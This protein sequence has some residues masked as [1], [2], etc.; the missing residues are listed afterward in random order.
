M[1]YFLQPSKPLKQGTRRLYGIA[2]TLHPSH[3]LKRP[4]F[5]EYAIERLYPKIGRE[6]AS[7]E[8]A[9]LE[10]LN[11]AVIFQEGYEP[12]TSPESKV[13]PA[14]LYNNRYR[15]SRQF[16]VIY[17]DEGFPFE[18]LSSDEE[19]E[20]HWLR[21]INENLSPDSRGVIIAGVYHLKDKLYPKDLYTDTSEFPKM[22]SDN[23]IKLTVVL[24][25]LPRELI[26]AI[27]TQRF[28]ER[29]MH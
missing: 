4:G 1:D 25:T 26:E 14:W 11:P 10:E 9:C 28:R 6:I 22:L 12:S 16:Q 13:N 24:Q 5:L 19:R 2:E 17:L 18:S 7:A 29:H 27:A 23:G 8:M 21:L 15:N 20:S 3:L